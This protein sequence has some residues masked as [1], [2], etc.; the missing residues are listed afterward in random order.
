M[1]AL[2]LGLDALVDKFARVKVE[3]GEKQVLLFGKDCG[4]LREQ[5]R[6]HGSAHSL[7]VLVQAASQWKL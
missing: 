7:F 6:M 5:M 1:F 3:H 2:Q 4:E